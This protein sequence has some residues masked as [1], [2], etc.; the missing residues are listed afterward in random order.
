MK[1]DLAGEDCSTLEKSVSSEIFYNQILGTSTDPNYG[2]VQIAAQPSGQKTNMGLNCLF[3]SLQRIMIAAVV[4]IEMHPD[5]IG[6][7]YYCISRNMPINNP[8]NP[9]GTVCFDGIRLYD[10]SEKKLTPTE[11]IGVVTNAAIAGCTCIFIDGFERIDFG[12]YQANA[13]NEL[14]GQLINLANKYKLLIICTSQTNRDASGKEIVR[15]DQLAYSSDK[16][17]AAAMVITLGTKINGKL[18]TACIV[19]NRNGKATNGTVFRL[20]VRPSLRLEVMDTCPAPSVTSDADGQEVLRVNTRPDDFPD[21]IDK[22]SADDDTGNETVTSTSR[23]IKPYH[24]TDGY[25]P[26]QRRVF[27]APIFQNRE[28]ELQAWLFQLFEMA[29]FEDGMPYAPNTRTAVLVHRGELLTS[30]DILAHRWGLMSDKKVRGIL[31]TLR[32][33]GLIE[34]VHVSTDGQRIP[35]K[36]DSTDASKDAKHRVIGTVIRVCHYEPKKKRDNADTE[37]ED[38]SLDAPMDSMRTRG[39]RNVDGLLNNVNKPNNFK[40]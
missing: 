14:L 36:N 16:A 37:K 34:L 7:R 8:Q 6:L 25:I 20:I 29:H 15:V 30:L 28:L 22:D 13:Y 1:Q 21:D 38:A 33:E 27:T 26:I 39:R 17:N 10:Y 5:N 12:S 9:P 32:D 11:L 18:L 24:G 2:L 4:S 23:S 35:V 19:K 40:I 3:Q 31:K